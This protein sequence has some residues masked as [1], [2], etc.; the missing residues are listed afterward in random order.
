MTRTP[1]TLG[2]VPLLD[3][4]PLI[5][6]EALGFAKEEGLSLTLKP[7]PSWAAL[8]DLLAQGQ[9]AAA[10]MLAP[11]PIAMALGLT[12][13]PARFEAL[14]VLNAN[15]DVL[16]V[17]QTIAARLRDAGFAF[18]FVSARTAALALA[19]VAGTE[20]LRIGVPFPFSMHT[21]LVQYWLGADGVQLPF[22]FECRTVPPPLMAQALAAG[23]IDAF[24]VGEPWGS[25][26]VERGVGTL[27]LPGSAIW[28]FAPEKVLATRKGWADAHPDLAGP[29]L[30]A[31]WR[32]G[33]W[34][35]EASN[36]M[37]ASEVLAERGRIDVAPELIER[38][39]EGRITISPRGEERHT[40]HLIEFFAGAATFPWRSQ[41][42]WI[43]QQLA[44]RYG[45]D[46]ALADH[47]ARAVFRPDI[48]RAH[49]RMAGADLPGASEKL[50]GALAAPT[51]VASER[52]RMILMADRFFD[53]RVFDP[54]LGR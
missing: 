39:L 42:A 46:P 43:G 48:Y 35:G 7:A 4:S 13:G 11:L 49:L 24:A 33:Q 54:A 17:S 34:L 8:R 30:R 31:V 41:A 51:T 9:V 12:A 47:E 6:A 16:G 10:Q 40:P 44:R 18:D 3:A 15:G 22:G 28:T 25:V 27:I 32:A 37:T 52:G 36:W 5:V 19:D 38:A 50:E 45:L 14:S 2:Y 29:L 26:A 21:E 20:P 1:L 53:A 23:E